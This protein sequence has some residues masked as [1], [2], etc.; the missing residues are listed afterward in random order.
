MS[1]A[2]IFCGVEVNV[3]VNS[4]SPPVTF[5]T[6]KSVS[7]CLY[8]FQVSLSLPTQIRSPWLQV[9]KSIFKIE[10]KSSTINFTSFGFTYPPSFTYPVSEAIYVFGNG[11]CV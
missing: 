1:P 9:A 6:L 8:T 4:V 2:L 7:S 5:S 11:A 10:L 3:T